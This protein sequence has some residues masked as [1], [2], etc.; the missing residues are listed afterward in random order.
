[1]V[2]H[3]CKAP[4]HTINVQVNNQNVEKVTCTKFL[5]VMLDDKLRFK[6]HINYIKSKISKGIGVLC[7]A[8][9]FFDVKTLTNLYYAFVHPYLHYCVEIWGNSGSTALS[10][11]VKLPK[12]AVRII[13]GV[14]RYSS[15]DYIFKMLS[16]LPF[17]KL[18]TFTVYKFI[19][20]IFHNIT[21]AVIARTFNLNAD[22]HD[23]DT[24]HSS[25]FHVQSISTGMRKRSLRHQVCLLHNSTNSI[26]YDI[27]FVTF[28][29]FVKT[30][31]LFD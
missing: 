12:A 22:V 30:I 27:P 25:K 28:K 16:I 20:N 10:A 26:E 9:K 11:L 8:K 7:R 17:G 18:H 14:N 31:L 5:G 23:H 4:V 2:F 21:P 1:M 6:D 3:N 24:R 29:Y 13:A 19:Y 15:T